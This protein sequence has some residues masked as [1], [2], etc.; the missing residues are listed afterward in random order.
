MMV[1]VL[2]VLPTRGHLAHMNDQEEKIQLGMA[3]R[4]SGWGLL[5][6]DSGVN[7]SVVHP[8]R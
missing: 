1:V 4:A 3:T 2:P 6:T 7:V 8:H 5:S